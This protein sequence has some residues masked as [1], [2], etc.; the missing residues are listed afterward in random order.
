MRKSSE[1]ENQTNRATV[2]EKLLE[3]HAMCLAE[4]GR[5]KD[6]VTAAL[7]EHRES[8]KGLATYISRCIANKSGQEFAKD[9]AKYCYPTMEHIVVVC[10]E[11]YFEQST[12]E[13]ARKTLEE[14]SKKVA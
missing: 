3:L 8:L 13:A 4:A 2:I 11:D 9:R 14:S 12:V 5:S 1:Q 10:G 7:N 6:S